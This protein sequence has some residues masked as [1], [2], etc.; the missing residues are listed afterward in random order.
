[1]HSND[2]ASSLRLLNHETAQCLKA[3]NCIQLSQP[4]KPAPSWAGNKTVHVASQSWPSVAFVA[5]WG[6]PQPWRALSLK[7]RR[8]L[9]C[10][11]ANSG[12]AESLEVALAQCGCSL[13]SEVAEAAALGGSVPACETLLIREGCDCKAHLEDVAAEAGHL[14]LLRWLRQPRRHEL[15]PGFLTRRLLEQQAGQAMPAVRAC[16]G[17]HAH[18]L[19]WL[20][21]EQQRQQP[22]LGGIIAAGPWTLFRP[23]SVLFLAGAAGAGGHVQLLDQLLPRLEPVSTGAECYMLGQVAQGCPLE[24]LQRAYN[25]VFQANV[26]PNISIKQTLAIAAAVSSTPDWEQKLDW[27][28][29]QQPHGA[30][31][32]GH[33]NPDDDFFKDVDTLICGAFRLPDW[34]QRLQAL[35]ARKVPLPPLSDLVKDAAA[36]GDVAVLTWLL[37][38]QG[39]GAP[40]LS[41]DDW[42]AVFKCL[43]RQGADL[44]TLRQLH[45][46][47]GAPIDLE[48][49]ARH[50]SV[51][52]LEWAVGALRGPNGGVEG[53]DYLLPSIQRS[54]VW[55][56]AAAGNLAAADWLVQLLASH[57]VKPAPPPA[58]AVAVKVHADG[59]GTF[60]ALR[61][62]L[63]QRQEG[64]CAGPSEQQEGHGKWQEQQVGPL[65]YT[66]WQK[67]LERVASSVFARTDSTS[68]WMYSRALWNWLV[69][70]RLEAAAQEEEAGGRVG[71]VAVARMEAAAAAAAAQNAAVKAEADIRARRYSELCAQIGPGAA[72]AL[73]AAVAASAAARRARK[74]GA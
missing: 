32:P 27:V 11:A 58:W 72:A 19:A 7:Q 33:P 26:H 46:R 28:L 69:A 50:G 67:L 16:H 35:R 12:C 61:W 1:M 39:E 68:E 60:G 37:A 9:L 49:V 40:D 8:Q 20:Q 29:Q 18:I 71:A 44:V 65:T 15:L 24:A 55:S 56:A 41:V 25:H 22:G 23:T 17:G 5:H 34:L 30:D 53:M 13:T 10:L 21:E 74:V 57:G 47:H 62:W 48:A 66:E 2:V 14:E 73:A 51:E 31:L 52:A 63:R 45:E 6:R 43:A 64:R 3:H 59:K 54:T 4:L 42:A 38:D 36:A 70:K